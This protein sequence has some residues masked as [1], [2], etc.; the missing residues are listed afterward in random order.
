MFTEIIRLPLSER[1]SKTANGE[2][3]SAKVML[4]K[5]NNILVARLEQSS[6]FFPQLIEDTTL[7]AFY[8][9]KKKRWIV[10]FEDIKHYRGPIE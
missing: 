9:D 3:I 6:F 1:D 8:H 7:R 2:A 10:P 5:E 4:I